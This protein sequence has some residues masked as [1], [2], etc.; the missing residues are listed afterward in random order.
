MFVATCATQRKGKKPNDEPL[1]EVRESNRE[2]EKGGRRA[3]R[4]G[5]MRSPKMQAKGSVPKEEKR[6]RLRKKTHSR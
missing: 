5:G 6:E 2:L 3:T 1:S 4:G